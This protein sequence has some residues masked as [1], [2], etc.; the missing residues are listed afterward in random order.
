MPN[1][2]SAMA[3]LLQLMAFPSKTT[4]MLVYGA[5]SALDLFR[6]VVLPLYVRSE[7]SSSRDMVILTG[8]SSSSSSRS[9]ASGRTSGQWLTYFIRR[10]WRNDRSNPT[11]VDGEEVGAGAEADPWLRLSPTSPSSTHPP[12]SS[13]SKPGRSKC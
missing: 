5:T 3:F 8:C 13:N 2:T 10:S 11:W 4:N 9:G 7:S 12:E 1:C 6:L